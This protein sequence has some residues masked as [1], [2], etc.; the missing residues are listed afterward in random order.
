[1]SNKFSATDAA[2][3]AGADAACL[4]ERRASCKLRALALPYSV[5]EETQYVIIRQRHR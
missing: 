5:T 3:E 2:C 4:P 1:M